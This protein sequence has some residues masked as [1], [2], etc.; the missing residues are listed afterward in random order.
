MAVDKTADAVNALHKTMVMLRQE[1][2]KKNH[3]INYL[4][5][6]L[7]NDLEIIQTTTATNI[8]TTEANE[9]EEEESMHDNQGEN[10][11][12][13]GIKFVDESSDI[14]RRPQKMVHLPHLTL[15]SISNEEWKIAQIFVAFSEYLNFTKAEPSLEEG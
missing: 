6:R 1:L 15:L 12:I 2:A 7:N 11:F 3:K 5:A 9:S 14:L 10:G 13:E 4:E 8:E